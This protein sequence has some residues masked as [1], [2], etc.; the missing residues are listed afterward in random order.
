MS[1]V[2]LLFSFRKLLSIQDLML[3]MQF[4]M[5]EGMSEKMDLVEM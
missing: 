5:V 1:S 3:V 2:L 4:V